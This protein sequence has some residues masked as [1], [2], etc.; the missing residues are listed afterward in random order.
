MKLLLLCHLFHLVPVDASLSLIGAAENFSARTPPP[1]LHSPAFLFCMFLSLV[2]RHFLYL[3]FGAFEF[4]LRP[5][6]FLVIS[7]H[8]TFS[9]SI[10]SLKSSILASDCSISSLNLN[11]ASGLHCFHHGFLPSS[12]VS[13]STA[14]YPVSHLL[15]L[16]LHSDNLECLRDLVPRHEDPFPRFCSH[17]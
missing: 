12:A 5:S 1:F 6:A 14:S 4:S 11:D 17:A 10:I 7:S 8:L 9:A 16:E 3:G 13:S 2:F 15:Q